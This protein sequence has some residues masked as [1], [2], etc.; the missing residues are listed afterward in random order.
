M[1]LSLISYENLKYSIKNYSNL[2][3]STII[4]TPTNIPRIS[5][6]DCPNLVS[7]SNSGITDTVA[8]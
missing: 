8:M 4:K 7:S 6:M 1:D 5:L 3:I 2:A